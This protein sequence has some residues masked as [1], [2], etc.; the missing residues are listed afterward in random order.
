VPF[1]AVLACAALTVAGCAA[2]S[3][4][5]ASATGSAS[6][7][8]PSASPV[9]PSAPTGP[10][11]GADYCPPAD[12]DTAR[13]SAPLTQIPPFT[14]PPNVVISARSTVSLAALQQALAKWET[15]STA[16]SWWGSA[17]ELVRRGGAIR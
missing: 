12:W 11:C 2:A 16:T 8:P 4:S 3:G 6:P 13:A 1:A 15:V 5:P 10:G 17:G 9:P 14:E 7:V